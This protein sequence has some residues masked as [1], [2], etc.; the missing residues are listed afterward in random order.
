MSVQITVLGLN[1]VGQSIGLALGPSKSQITRVGSDASGEVMRQAQKSGAFDKVLVN[2]PE[3]VRQAD[4]VILCLPLDE[5]RKTMEAIRLDLKPGV[6]VLDTSPVPLRTAGWA[7]ELLPPQNCYFLSFTPAVNPAYLHAG[8]D[9]QPEPH[10][11]YFQDAV[12]FISHPQ[13][14]DPSAI[15]FGDNLARLLGATPVFSEAHE[16]EGLLAL[17][18]WL[19]LLASA[20]VLGAA[21]GQPGWKEARKLAGPEF[22]LAGL[23]LGALPNDAEAAEAL[24]EARENALRM[25]DLLRGELDE[26]RTLLETRDDEALAARMKELRRMRSDWIGRR[27]RAN[28]DEE[29]DRRPPLPTMGDVLGRLVGIKPRGERGQDKSR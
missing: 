10:A 14:I 29:R 21:A 18:R 3:A 7:G 15:E 12:V 23:G 4:A 8:A 28:W 9:G 16:V 5:M 17:T 27:A 2:L 11:D 1:A 20:A 24:A 13:G 6:V 22:A 25:V 19:P 26:L